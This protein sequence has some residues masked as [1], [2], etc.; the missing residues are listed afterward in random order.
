MPCFLRLCNA[1]TAMNEIQYDVLVIGAGAAG[2]NAARMLAQAGRRVAVL[3]AR[4]RVGGRIWTR[5]DTANNPS[6]KLPIELGAEFIH[7]LPAE[8]WSLV[9]EASLSTYELSGASLWFSGGGLKTGNQ[10]RGNA[11]R[12][13]E[14][15][16]KWVSAQPRLEDLSFADYMKRIG[17]DSASAQ[18]ATNYVEGFNAADQQRI[19][20]ASLAQQQ[21]AED[22][23]SADRLFRVKAGY[24][25]IPE[26]LA[27]LYLRAGGELFLDAEVRKIV[28]KPGDIAVETAL[29]GGIRSFR[30][31]RVLIT[32]PLGVLQNESIEFDPR[33]VEIL[34]HAS[35]LAMGA[36]MRLGLVFERKLW[37]EPM[38]FLFAPSELPPTWWTPMPNEAPALTAWAGGPKAEALLR[39]AADGNADALLQQCLFSLAKSLGRPLEEIRRALSSWHFHNWH[40]DPFARGAYSYVPAGALDAPEKMQRPVEDTLYFAGEHTDTSGH[41]GTVHAALATGKTAALR[42]L[43]SDAHG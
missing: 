11:E 7:G 40:S 16:T 17:V 30:T 25:A 18:A 31:A 19:S 1:S 32:V 29:R 24:S 39:L 27:Q 33:P 8:T 15:M 43:G 23:I 42:I 10:Q 36:V 5:A 28:W 22:A 38:S 34:H 14:E 35:R 37:S 9:S 4:D 13:I 3:E 6:H 21:R 41:W 26:F 2:L 12:V 20:V